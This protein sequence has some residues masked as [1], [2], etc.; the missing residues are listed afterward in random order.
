MH[1]APARKTEPLFRVEFIGGLSVVTKAPNS[2]KAEQKARRRH[3]GI[4]SKVRILTGARA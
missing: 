1:P 2:L 4:V 3:P